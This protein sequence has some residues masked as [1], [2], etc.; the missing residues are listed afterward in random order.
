MSQTTPA[1]DA[2]QSAASNSDAVGRPHDADEGEVDIADQ[3][4]PQQV[5]ANAIPDIII[6]DAPAEEPEVSAEGE[7]EDEVKDSQHVRQ[8]ADLPPTEVS[9]FPQGMG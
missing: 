2:D 4:N 3:P 7:P 1:K 9:H 6:E 8:T 5:C